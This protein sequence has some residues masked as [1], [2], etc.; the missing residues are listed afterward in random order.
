MMLPLAHALRVAQDGDPVLDD[1]AH[2]T[3]R[4]TMIVLSWV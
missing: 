4:S 1:G 2:G 3:A